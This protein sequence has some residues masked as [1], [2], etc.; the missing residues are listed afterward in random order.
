MA[1]YKVILA[2]DG[3]DFQGFQR[4]VKDRTVQASVEAALRSIGWQNSTI[5]GAGRTDTGVH[6]SGQV[7][8][9]E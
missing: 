3:T 1:H 2:Y 4:Q 9:F 7:I 6:A 5:L 8:A